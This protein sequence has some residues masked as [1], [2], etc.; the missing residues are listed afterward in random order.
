MV[1]RVELIGN[2]TREP[3]LH[4]SPNG[5]PY[6]YL[7]LA[8]NRFA[9]GVEH[10]DFHFIT[11]WRQLAESCAEFLATGA[12]I[13]VEGR[14]ETHVY[15]ASDGSRVER[16]RITASLVKFL[17]GAR[18]QR[19]SEPESDEV[20]PASDAPSALG[21]VESFSREPAEEGA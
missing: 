6:C 14:L 9:S 1:N 12:R 2:L 7:R 10:T 5:V 19:R 4:Y 16:I 21:E 15:P 11:A 20:A 18:R 8:S 13:Y 3:E 17:D